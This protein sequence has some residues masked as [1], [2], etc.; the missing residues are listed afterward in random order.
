MRTEG[1]KIGFIVFLAVIAALSFPRPGFAA[2]DEARVTTDK[3]LYRFGESIFVTYFNAPGLER[4]WICV[5]GADAPDTAGG[6]Y[7]YLPK[8][9]RE[10]MLTFA[11]PAPGKY[12]VRAY[13]HYASRGYVVA[14]R[15]AFTVESSPAYEKVV[16]DEAAKFARPVDPANSPE[17]EAGKDGGLVYLFRRSQAA[18]NRVDAEVRMEGKTVAVM[19]HTTFLVLPV[20]AGDV[21]LSPGALSTYNNQQNKKEEVWTLE[22]GEATLNIKAG[23]VYYVQLTVSYRGGYGARMEL[24]P[25]KEGADIIAGDRLKSLR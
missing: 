14:A 22:R 1:K 13:Y 17:A 20:A 4:D 10:G 2:A 15:H 8:D 3:Q 11:T 12:E 25:H 24:I 21:A 6:D 19:P 16:A 5:V 9:V 7:Q 23:Y 18:S